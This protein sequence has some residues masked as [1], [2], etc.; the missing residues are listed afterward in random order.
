MLL[1]PRGKQ[2]QEKHPGETSAGTWFSKP[3]PNPPPIVQSYGRQGIFEVE[4]RQPKP[5]LEG[6]HIK[7]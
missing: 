6:W 3:K 5:N 4:G 2:T 1:K 7:S